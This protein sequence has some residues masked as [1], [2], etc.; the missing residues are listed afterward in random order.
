MQ[1]KLLSI[2]IMLSMLATQTV[3][4][5]N[6]D[7]KNTKPKKQPQKV[8]APR[9]ND[10]GIP[11]PKEG[12]KS[13]PEIFEFVEQMPEYPSGEE[14]M[15]AYIYD[16]LKVPV[17]MQVNTISG[18]TIVGFYI[19]TDGDMKNLH[20][21]RSLSNEWDNLV[22]KAF[23]GMARW[24]PGK[25]NGRAVNVAYSVS[26]NCNLGNVSSEDVNEPASID[27]EPTTKVAS[28]EEE[29]Y[30]FVEQMA[31]FPGGENALMKFLSQN[32]KYPN[33]ARENN[34]KGRV[35]VEFIVHTDG[36]IYGIKVLRGI[37]FGCDEEVIRVVK[38]MPKWM[39]AK[40]NGKPVAMRYKLPVMFA[41]K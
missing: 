29:V 22:L 33:A 6:A 39:P 34:I 3:I 12:P 8:D 32:I 1:I 27:T 7:E 31:E 10:P 24:K 4:A 38:S 11:P 23:E 13:S 40:M 37:G 36:S 14:A 15:Y 26:V 41:M 25:Q 20:I 16:H 5:Q 2:G 19:D 9:Y 21:Q 30:D 35:F 17:E 28:G 18:R